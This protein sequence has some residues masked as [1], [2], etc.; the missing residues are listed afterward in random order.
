MPGGLQKIVHNAPAIAA[1][2][3]VRVTAGKYGSR[4]HM[5]PASGAWYK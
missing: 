4:A 1:S 5:P 2:Q 3:L